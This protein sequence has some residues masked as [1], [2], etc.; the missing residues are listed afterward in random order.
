MLAGDFLSDM[1][2]AKLA[3]AAAGVLVVGVVVAQRAVFWI[4]CVIIN[5]EASADAEERERN[6]Y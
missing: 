5:R 4:Q 2:D 3:V 1:S 6:R